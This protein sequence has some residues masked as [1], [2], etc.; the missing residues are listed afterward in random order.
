MADGSRIQRAQVGD[1][2]VGVGVGLE[3]GNVPG[4]SRAKLMADSGCSMFNLAVYILSKTGL[5]HF[6]VDFRGELRV[7][8]REQRLG[9]F[10]GT[11]GAA[12]NTA[13]GTQGTVPVGAGHAAVQGNFVDFGAK[14]LLHFVIQGVI[15][16]FVPGHGGFPHIINV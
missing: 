4:R 11:S 2:G 13:P 1:G 14:M 15:W 5:L 3:V 10:S 9:K 6:R 7:R 8:S 16:L 12:E